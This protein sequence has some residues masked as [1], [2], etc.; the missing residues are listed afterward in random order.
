MD[1]FDKLLEGVRIPAF[2][3]VHFEIEHGTIVR[4]DIAELVEKEILQK[5]LLSAVKEGDTVAVT[6]GS[7]GITNYDQIVKCVVD[8]LKKA[9]AH[10]FIFPA[11]EAMGA[12]WQKD[13][14][15]FWRA[16]VLRKRRWE[17]RL[18]LRWRQS[19]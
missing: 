19:R 3:P 2:A 8:V 16:M 7:R 14:A 6:A 18:S 13:S 17:Y 15:V 9:G 5:G 4:E 1:I 11:M 10:P 12:R